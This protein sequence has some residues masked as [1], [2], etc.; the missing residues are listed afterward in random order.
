[1]FPIFKDM[2]AWSQPE[3]PINPMFV[4]PIKHMY[5]KHDSMKG[6]SCL[7]ILHIGELNVGVHC[8]DLTAQIESVLLFCMRGM[9]LGYDSARMWHVWH[10]RMRRGGSSAAAPQGQCRA[11]ENISQHA[12]GMSP[13]LHPIA[14]LFMKTLCSAAALLR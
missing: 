9:I 6:F 13:N 5:V 2:H 7:C 14:S 12:L 4:S 3:F 8:D 1:M 11:A 10:V